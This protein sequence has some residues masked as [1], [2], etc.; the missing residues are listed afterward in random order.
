[1]SD[2]AKPATTGGL[3]QRNVAFAVGVFVTSLAV[4]WLTL[5]PTVTLVDSGELILAARSLGVAHPPGFPLYVMLAHLA[6]L[7]PIGNVAARV[8][9]AS[10]IFAASAAAVLSLAV[11]EATATRVA[12]PSDRKK[13]ADR[14]SKKRST[15]ATQPLAENEDAQPLISSIPTIIA[16]LLLAFS[17]TL[18]A[19]ATIAE[20]YTLNTLLIAGIIF[21]MFRWRRLRDE[22]GRH[23]DKATGREDER[24]GRGDTETRRKA[25][26]SAA[27]P[28]RLVAVSPPL[29]FSPPRPVSQSPSR[30][31]YAA[32]LL[33]GIALGVH[34]VTV[35]LML[36]AFAALVLATEGV[37][38]FTSK[39]LLYAALFAFAGLFVV[40][41]YLPIAASRE[42]V[43][44]WGEPRT[45][46]RL[47]WHITGKQYQVF[48]SFSLETAAKQFGEFV[49]LAAREF[50]PWWLP[51]APALA[52]AGLYSLFRRDRVLFWFLGLMIIAD[53]AYSLGYE[54]AE[55]KDAYYLPLF[56]AMAIAAGFGAQ[57]LINKLAHKI[58]PPRARY[59][60]AAFAIVPMIA[61]ISNLQ[62][63]NRSHYYI[64]QDYT[65]NILSTIAPGGMLL[66]RDWQVYSP[67]LY[68]REIE[69][70]RDDA[71]VI[72]INQLRRSW[73]YAYLERV[74]PSTI[75]QARDE[76][77][78]FLEDLRH[79]EQDP[80]LYQRDLTLNERINTRFF[81][82]IRAFVTN[83]IRS[84]PVYVTMD[85]ATNRDG[86][87]SE[88]TKSLASSYQFIPQGLVFRLSGSREFQQL[89]EPKLITRGL[90]DG[91]LKFEDDDVVKLKVLP[92]YVTM[93]YN[94]GR[95][96][97]VNGHHEE[98]IEL[99]KQALAF[100]PNFSPAQKAINESV[101]AMRKANPN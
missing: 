85:V 68:V 78:A 36:P 82:M 14:K 70:R 35:G 22:R 81:D 83:H 92:V 5:A 17:R 90:A 33:F 12:T 93:L 48:L 7:I 72:D 27:S 97:A 99:F 50:G 44:N 37:R 43:M 57:W 65:D 62:Y 56:L 71:V 32:S 96:L 39:R 40:Y 89:A 91:T 13:R 19:Y 61:L 100:D 86:P 79:W 42:P 80:D 3:H 21:L 88:L 15:S 101:A 53:L 46:Q 63:N 87:D 77:D 41:S 20:V 47:W 6:T 26:T 4:Y 94:R 9:F 74:Y 8:N 55:D 76:V 45:L 49:S 59:A 23:G 29:I 24:G 30:Y 66:T 95:Y 51:V 64:A 67:M 31:L 2:A 73:Y 1:M 84:A 58:S 34:H 18:W 60:A 38:F 98:A 16:A 52:I 11:F 10:A 75:A 69:H 28:R 54:I 25:D